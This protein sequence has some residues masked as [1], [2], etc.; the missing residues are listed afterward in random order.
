M[1]GELIFVLRTER[2]ILFKIKLPHGFARRRAETYREKRALH[3]Q[4]LN[5]PA[6]TKDEGRGANLGL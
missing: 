6:T 2:E 3:R 5:P 1:G 4:S